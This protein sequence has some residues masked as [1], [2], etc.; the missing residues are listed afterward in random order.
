METS[1]SLGYRQLLCAEC[2]H[3]VNVDGSS[4][5]QYCEVP[6]HLENYG[7]SRERLGI[8]VQLAVIESNVLG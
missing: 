7:F 3:I 2:Q 8:D 5:H 6:S 1:S 4:I